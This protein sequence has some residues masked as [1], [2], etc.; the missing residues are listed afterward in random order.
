MNSVAPHFNAIHNRSLICQPLVPSFSHFRLGNVRFSK[1]NEQVVMP[2]FAF[3]EAPVKFAQV[4][5]VEARG[6]L[7]HRL[8]AY[9]PYGPNGVGGFFLGLERLKRRFSGKR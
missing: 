8:H 2:R 4:F 6:G 9:E 1:I 7:I 3:H 5:I